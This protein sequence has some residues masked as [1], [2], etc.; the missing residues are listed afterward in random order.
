M[1]RSM[2]EEVAHQALSLAEVLLCLPILI[3]N[4]LLSPLWYLYLKVCEVHQR[5]G[6]TNLDKPSISE[7]SVAPTK[8][9]SAGRWSERSN[10]P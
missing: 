5:S 9:D 8:D 6:L 1:R 7:R 10:K 4:F 3:A 2:S